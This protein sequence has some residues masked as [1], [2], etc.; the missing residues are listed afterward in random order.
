MKVRDFER[1]KFKFGFV[2]CLA[3]DSEGRSG[4]LAMLWG[5][6][7]NLSIISYSKFHIDAYVKE[8]GG[9]IMQYFITGIYGHPNSSQRHKT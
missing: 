3:V 8:D 4:G 5:R 1:L 6:D 2:N 9:R 7:I